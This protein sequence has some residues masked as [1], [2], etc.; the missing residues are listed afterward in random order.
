[1]KK[2]LKAILCASFILPSLASAGTAVIPTFEVWQGAT[3]CYRIS[4]ISNVSTNVTVRFYGK[5]GESYTGPM[6]SLS[7]IETLGSPFTLNP[8]QTA[9]FCLD[10]SS[11]NYGYGV[12]ESS[13]SGAGQAYLV[14]TGVYHSKHTD[15][16]MTEHMI[17]VNNGMPF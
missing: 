9:K 4:N 11:H 17:P 8:Q 15:Y 2:V 1:M 10:P 7:Y 5:N 3:S 16:T 14:A 6:S 13:A 12:I